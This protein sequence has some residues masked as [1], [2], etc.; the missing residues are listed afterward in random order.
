M[1]FVDLGILIAVE[2]CFRKIALI[3]LFLPQHESNYT[4]LVD[5]IHV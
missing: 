5:L 1:L 2:V 3:K 4:S